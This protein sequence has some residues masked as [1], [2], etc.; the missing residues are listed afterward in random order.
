[1]SSPCT[2]WYKNNRDVDKKDCLKSSNLPHVVLLL[3]LREQ[4]RFVQLALGEDIEVDRV[5][6]EVRFSGEVVA[7]SARVRSSVGRLEVLGGS[8][9]FFI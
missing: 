5:G 1:M 6:R 2:T 9:V 8:G 4:S 7:G 3:R